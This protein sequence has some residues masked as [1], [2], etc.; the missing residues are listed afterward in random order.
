M[1]SKSFRFSQSYCCTRTATSSFVVWAQSKCAVFDSWSKQTNTYL[2]LIPSLFAWLTHSH[3]QYLIG[4]CTLLLDN[5]EAILCDKMQLFIQ[6]S[7]FVKKKKSSVLKPALWNLTLARW[8]LAATHNS[9]VQIWGKLWQW[10]LGVGC[11]F[12]HSLSCSPNAFTKCQDQSMKAKVPIQPVK[13]TIS[14][15]SPLSVCNPLKEGKNCPLSLSLHL[16]SGL[17]VSISVADI[18]SVT[19]AEDKRGLCCWAFSFSLHHLLFL[20]EYKCAALSG[21]LFEKS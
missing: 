20:N 10:A 21:A 6:N 15:H 5:L 18:D 4:S 14:K 19:S 9:Y 7:D 17:W 3:R 8:H 16:P 2:S 1:P 12:S 11:F 13:R